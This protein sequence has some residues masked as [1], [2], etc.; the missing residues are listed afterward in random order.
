M[1]ISYAASCWNKAAGT[2]LRHVLDC[3][4]DKPLHPT[5]SNDTGTV[6][7]I[8][9]DIVFFMEIARVSMNLLCSTVP[10][11]LSLP[12][13][14]HRGSLDEGSR[15]ERLAT[16]RVYLDAMSCQGGPVSKVDESSGGQYRVGSSWR[17][18]PSAAQVS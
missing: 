17:M 12:V 4:T 11:S 1:I 13:A 3:N 15:S 7:V 8:I 9:T 5:L 18:Y 10:S 16:I 2:L 6:L 14:G